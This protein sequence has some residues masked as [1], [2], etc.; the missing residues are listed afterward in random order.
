MRDILFFWLIT[1]APSIPLLLV[2]F[3]FTKVL[4]A[5]KFE[6][7]TLLQRGE[8]LTKYLSAYG[9]TRS[10]QRTAEDK[11]KGEQEEQLIRNIVGQIFR[12]R[13]SVLEYVWAVIFNVSVNILLV[14]LGL[15][16]AGIKLGLPD[17]LR[18]YLMGN[19]YLQDIVAGGIGAL[20]W[21]VYEL[22][23]R[24][25]FGDLSPDVIF[26]AG[27]RVL[28]AGSAGAIVGVFV[29]DRFAW[30]VAFGLGVLPVSYT[31]SF[32]VER[33]RKILNLPSPTISQSKPPLTALQGWNAELLERLARAGV[34]SIQ[35]LACTNQFQL[36]LRSNLEWRVLLDLS[37]QA[38]LMM[39]IGEDVQKLYPLG[40]R[41]AVEIAEIDWSEDDKTFFSGFTRGQAIQKI[42]ALLNSDE[43]SV[44]MLI[45]SISVD[46]T[47]NFLGAL[48]SEDTPDD[49]EDDEG[50]SGEN[51]D[52]SKE[53]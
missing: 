39:Y 9:G 50:D 15:S 24:Y 27:A 40:I 2:V 13:Y 43:L 25:R 26:V 32:V 33:A 41:S 37:D 45:K 49:D 47:V 52:K 17:L 10:S 21:S 34:T 44:Q 19:F 18:G 28:F 5:K 35:E 29:N 20:V 8:T 14:V 36:F 31:R 23:E 11:S 46:A 30:A 1:L 7:Q 48:W 38:L 4:D 42:A 16:F 6:V 51:Q 53:K 12:L 3:A 22:S